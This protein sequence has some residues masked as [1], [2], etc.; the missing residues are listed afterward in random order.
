M[1]RMLHGLGMAVADHK[2]HAPQRVRVFVVTVSDSRTEDTDTSGRA[3]RE[4]IEAAGHVVA[5][6]RLLKDV[7]AEMQ[8]GN[9]KVAATTKSS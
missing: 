8:K 6:Y 5:G 9:G 1:P 7:Q 4:L 2:Q 3:A